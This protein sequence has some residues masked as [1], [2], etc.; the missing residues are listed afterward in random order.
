[1]VSFPYKSTEASRCGRRSDLAAHNSNKLKHN[2]KKFV[3]F[4]KVNK[5]MTSSLEKKRPGL[6]SGIQRK[7]PTTRSVHYFT[8][9]QAS[10]LQTAKSNSWMHD[11]EGGSGRPAAGGVCFWTLHHRYTP[12]DLASS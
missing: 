12:S 2:S 3:M 5:E 4:D 10:G 7:A 6:I 8:L 9:P 1:M 11:G